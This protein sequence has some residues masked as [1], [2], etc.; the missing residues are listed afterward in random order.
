MRK[1]KRNERLVVCP[2]TRQFTDIVVCAA[3]CQNRCSVYRETITLDMLQKFIEE[4][5]EYE[6]IGEIMPEKAKAKA[7]TKE[8]KYWIV[9]DQN[10]VQE[11]SESMIMKNPQDF[12]GKQIW[13]KPPFKYDIVITLKRVK[14]ED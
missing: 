10:I 2:R 9:D 13:Q 8:N 3:S 5:P 14:A 4:H 12:I 1:K 11:V 6:I 7:K